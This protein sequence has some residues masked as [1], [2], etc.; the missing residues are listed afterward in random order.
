MAFL[1]FFRYNISD[2]AQVT[3]FFGD[4]PILKFLHKGSRISSLTGEKISER[5]VVEAFMECERRLGQ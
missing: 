5:Q 3:G 4:T 1:G 2:V